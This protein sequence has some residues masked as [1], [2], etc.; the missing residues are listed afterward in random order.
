[1]TEALNKIGTRKEKYNVF[2][3]VKFLNFEALRITEPRDL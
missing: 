1:M 3:V 2:K